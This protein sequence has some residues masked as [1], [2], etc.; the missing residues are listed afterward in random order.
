M[1]N[2][3]YYLVLVC[4]MKRSVFIKENGEKS[5]FLSEKKTGIAVTY[6]LEDLVSSKENNEFSSR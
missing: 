2:H 5:S 6:L 1:I 4:R 3:S